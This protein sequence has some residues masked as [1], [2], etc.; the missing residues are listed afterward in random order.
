L[1]GWTRQDPNAGAAAPYHS[2]GV[3]FDGYGEREALLLRSFV[4]EQLLES[5]TM[6]PAKLAKD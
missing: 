4:H 3:A 6:R 5:A 1:E 2:V